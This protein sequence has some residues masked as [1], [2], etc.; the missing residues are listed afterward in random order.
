MSRI[1]SLLAATGLLFLSSTAFAQEGGDG[2]TGD[3][4]REITG[5][6][7]MLKTNL[8]GLALTSINGN[9][10]YKTGGASSVGLLGGYKLPTTIT[11]NGWA[12]TVSD[13]QQTYTGE[14]EPSGWFINPYARIYA[15]EAFHGF[16][17][18]P[19]LRFFGFDYKVPYDYEKNNTTI[20][21]FADGEASGWGGGLGFGTS[22]DI[23]PRIFLDINLGFGIA[24]GDIYVITSD[25]NLDAQ[26]YQDIKAKIEENKNADVEILILG[27]VLDELEAGANETSAWAEM[28][29]V[30]MPI[31]RGGIHF[32]FAF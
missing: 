26:D 31:F 22:F 19:F 2:A 10:E 24:Q 9:I 8:V 21:A 16:Y 12:E 20:R 6:R 29:D 30:I 15:K 23:A 28:N 14:I 17:V 18:E 1:T 32:G 3:V 25:P 4:A 7:T 11:V 5:P 13:G 27:S